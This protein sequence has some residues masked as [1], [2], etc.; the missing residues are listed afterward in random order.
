MIDI[1]RRCPSRNF[2]GLNSEVIWWCFVAMWIWINVVMELASTSHQISSSYDLGSPS[3]YNSRRDDTV[4]TCPRN[5]KKSQN[6]FLYRYRAQDGTAKES[7]STFL[8]SMY[9][10]LFGN[11]ISCLSLDPVLSP[12]RI[13][14]WFRYHLIRRVVLSNIFYPD[15][16]ISTIE[17]A[18]VT[19]SF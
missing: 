4:R 1:F 18:C 8:L 13:I 3:D 17:F 11:K 15:I 7:G 14:Q 2:D 9:D 5:V 10:F 12:T 6:E 16:S 19:V